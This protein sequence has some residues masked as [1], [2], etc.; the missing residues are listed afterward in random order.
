[1]T[2]NWKIAGMKRID[3]T[4]LVV[5]VTYI[6]NAEEGNVLDRKVGS[7][8]FSGSTNEPGFVP[9]ED[10]T[11]EIVLGWVYNELGSEKTT[12]ENEVTER[13]QDRIDA[14]QNN[15]YKQGVPWN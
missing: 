12:I 14:Q 15:P 6:F 2:T 3:S 13:V 5:D 9:Y 7:M 4:G 8:T 10:L 11:E 1:M